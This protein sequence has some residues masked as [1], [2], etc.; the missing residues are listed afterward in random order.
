MPNPRN[1]KVVPDGD[2]NSDAPATE[3]KTDEEKKTYCLR[4]K[5]GK[6]LYKSSIPEQYFF[7]RSEREQDFARHLRLIITE[8]LNDDVDPRDIYMEGMNLGEA[9]LSHF[10]LTGIQMPGCRLVRADLRGTILRD[11]NLEG[12]AFGG[13]RMHDCDLTNA[14]IDD[15][16]LSDTES[17]YIHGI[18][19]LGELD[20]WRVYGYRKSDGH[21]RIRAGCRNFSLEDAREHWEERDDRKEI[22]AALSLLEIVAQNRE[23]KTVNEDP[24]PTTDSEAQKPAA[25]SEDDDNEY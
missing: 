8:A 22:F 11:A 14:N 24:A 18:I 13:A 15:V 10:D 12:C 20:G 5:E 17:G 4:D 1:K 7:Y 19:S 9:D 16:D 21:L 2:V 23:W 3:S 25:E 6:V